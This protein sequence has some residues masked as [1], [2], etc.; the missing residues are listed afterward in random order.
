MHAADFSKCAFSYHLAGFLIPWIDND[1][2][3]GQS[4]EEWKGG[5]EA[6]KIL[7]MPTMG[8]PRSLIVEGLC[9]RVGAMRYI[10]QTL[11]FNLRKDVSCEEIESLLNND[12]EQAYV[13]PN[14]KDESLE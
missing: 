10:S 7:G 1:L 4:R 14:R 11:T 5:V 8:I 12:N 6:N 3:N 13:V 9:V 2:R